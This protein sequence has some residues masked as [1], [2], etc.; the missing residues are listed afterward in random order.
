MNETMKTLLNRRSIRKYKSQQIKDEE[1]NAVLEAGKYAPSGA[2]QQSALFIVVQNKDA[3][4][5]ISKMNA[6]VMGKENVDP[7]YGAPTV[8][9]VLADKSK[10][11]PV[12]DASIALGN[13][14][15]AAYSLG[16]GSCWIHRT[17][18][19]FESE[20][21]K[22]LLKV[23]GVEGDYIGVGSCILGYPDCELPKAAPRK[24]NFVI[25]VK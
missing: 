20:E 24:E 18:E 10:A 17:R 2:N 22:K 7:Y 1:L 11:T 3:I 15:N 9:L 13:M 4:K 23:W 16:L 8:I 14:Y 12:E 5:K 25:M 19:M 21:G 6:A